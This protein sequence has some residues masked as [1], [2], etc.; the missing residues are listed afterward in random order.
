M[1]EYAE[2]HGLNANTAR[3][4][5][6]GIKAK[7]GKSD[8]YSDQKRDHSSDHTPDQ[9]NKRQSKNKTNNSAGR[10]SKGAAKLERETRANKDAENDHAII[11]TTK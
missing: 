4:Q 10:A 7:A 11:E 8:Q 3:V 9:D 1:R 2:A 6:K 5:L